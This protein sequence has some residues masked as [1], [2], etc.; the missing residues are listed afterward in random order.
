[1]DIDFGIGQ[2]ALVLMGVA[3]FA[4]G[5]WLLYLGLRRS[6]YIEKLARS[7]ER[8]GLPGNRMGQQIAALAGGAF[9]VVIG[10]WVFLL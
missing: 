5:V 6:D 4:F 3:S 9:F 10:L 2:Y 8:L 1:M 7:R